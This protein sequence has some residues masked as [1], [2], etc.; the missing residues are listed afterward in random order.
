MRISPPTIFLSVSAVKSLASTLMAT[1]S[2]VYAIWEVEL[3]PLQLVLMGTVLKGRICCL[4][5]RR[6]FWRK[7]IQGAGR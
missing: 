4:S 5:C 1:T 7:G 2:G 3:D 6:G